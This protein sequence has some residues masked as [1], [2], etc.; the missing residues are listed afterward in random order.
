MPPP[1]STKPSDSAAV[2]VY[3]AAL[4]HPMTALAQEVRAAILAA[5]P[6]VGEEI[7]W[8]A[9]AFFFTGA[10]DHFKPSEYRRHL[11]VFNFHRKNTLRL[12]VMHGD[13][14]PN[15]TGLLQGDSPDGR[16]VAT[17]CSVDDFRAQQ[18]ALQSVVEA[19]FAPLVE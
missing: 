19:L 18:T 4:R 5:H 9:P 6:L 3:M 12:V 16:R 17:F 2:D 1:K 13:R 10:M 14:A 15:D 8:N 11:V 7:K